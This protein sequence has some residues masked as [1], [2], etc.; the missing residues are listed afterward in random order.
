LAALVP[1]EAAALR[2]WVRE[3]LVRQFGQPVTTLLASLKPLAQAL[4]VALAALRALAD[5]L[6]AKLADLLAAPQALSD[7]LAD[8]AGVQQRLATLDLGVYTR[9]VDTVYNALLDQVRALDPR[10]LQPPLEAARDRLLGL[11]SLDGL[12]P[13]ELRGQ[14]GE[15]HRQLLGKLRS[16]DPDALLLQPLDQEYREIVE[17]LVAALDVG[18]T[19][20]VLIV[21]VNGLPED[22]QVQ[23][24]RVDVPY[25]QLLHSVP[26]GGGGGGS[27]GLSL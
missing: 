1:A 12:L 4:Q 15:A 14:L 18:A 7:L 10:H 20:D 11:I 2:A 5:A 13:A 26:A 9:E 17:P 27:A 21:W 16:L 3:A 19:V 6:Q 8:V 23:I 25:G 22:L 24:A